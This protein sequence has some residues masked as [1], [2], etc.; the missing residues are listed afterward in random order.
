MES[1]SVQESRRQVNNRASAAGDFNANAPNLASYSF[2]YIEAA[3][4]RFSI[5]NKLGEGGYGP[6]YKVIFY[7]SLKD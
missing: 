1:I 4:N 6:V 7:D 5:E 2:A 3:T